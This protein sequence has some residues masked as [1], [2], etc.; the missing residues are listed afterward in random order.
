MKA[1]LEAGGGVSDVLTRGAEAAADGAEATRTMSARKG[2]ASY[3]GDR[4]V[5]HPDPGAI[6]ASMMLRAA[7][8]IWR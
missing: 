1:A 4:S 7:A 3:I 8:D 2:R 5:G 6:A